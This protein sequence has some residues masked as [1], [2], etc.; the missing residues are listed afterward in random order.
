MALHKESYGLVYN[1]DGS[2]CTTI[3]EDDVPF[4]GVKSFA[5]EEGTENLVPNT[6]GRPDT[7]VPAGSTPPTVELIQENHPFGSE[8]WKITFPAGADTDF[9]GCRVKSDSWTMQ[10]DG[11]KYTMSVYI[12]GDTS[13]L[14]IY[15][16]GSHGLSDMT[17]T[18]EEINGYKRYVTTSYIDDSGTATEFLTIYLKETTTSDITIYVVASQVEAKP[19]ATSFVDETRPSGKFDLPDGS[20]DL[21]NKSFAIATWVK[22]PN[23]EQHERGIFTMGESG[24]NT[25]LHCIIRNGKPYL[26]FYANDLTSGTTINDNQWHFLVFWYDSTIKTQRIYI[27]GE[28]DCERVASNNFI[29]PSINIQIGKYVQNEKL[30]NGLLANFIIC[31]NIYNDQNNLIWTDEYI[32]EVYNARKPFKLPANIPVK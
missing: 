30:L 14:R 4:E 10:K 24:D 11:T 32:Q 29:G 20:I 28:K 8:V 15:H 22:I 31:D 16:T 9:S 7:M 25:L 6:N 13:K 12:K 18:G 27:D 17:A 2:L 23:V 3:R 21:A 26:G 5:V 1:D 19:F